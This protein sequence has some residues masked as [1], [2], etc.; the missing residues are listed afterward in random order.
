MALDA[1][2]SGDSHHLLF[3]GIASTERTPSPESAF[4]PRRRRSVPPRLSGNLA[5]PPVLPTP[6]EGSHLCSHHSV[7]LGQDEG[8]NYGKVPGAGAAVPGG[9][10]V[11]VPVRG[12]SDEYHKL[13]A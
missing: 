7:P 6:G 10:T 9:R 12:A 5:S 11:G 1:Q 4:L 3:S 13:A 8:S 2:G